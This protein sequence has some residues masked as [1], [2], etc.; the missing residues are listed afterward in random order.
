MYAE[1]ED[2]ILNIGCGNSRMTEDMYYDG[3]ETIMNI[4]MS[5]VVVEQMQ[6][7]YGDN[8]LGES[9]EFVQLNVCDMTVSGGRSGARCRGGRS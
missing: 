9:V 2:Y 1:P 4:D 5:R 7:K 6:D 8:D 3:Y